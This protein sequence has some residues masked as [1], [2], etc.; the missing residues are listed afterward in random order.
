MDPRD[1][2]TEVACDNCD[3]HGVVADYGAF[4]LDFEGPREC[5][6]CNGSGIVWKSPKGRLFEYPGGRIIGRAA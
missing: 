5:P 1:G 3:G 4:G 6:H 2:W